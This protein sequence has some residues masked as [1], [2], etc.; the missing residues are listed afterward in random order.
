MGL[1]KAGV[2]KQN[3][4]RRRQR[5]RKAKPFL[6]VVAQLVLSFHGPYVCSSKAEAEQ[7]ATNLRPQW[8]SG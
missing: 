4:R 1:R 6:A 8:A 2:K 5:R 3:G 7:R